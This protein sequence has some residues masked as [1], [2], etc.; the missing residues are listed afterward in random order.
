MIIDTHSQLRTAEA[1]QGINS[2]IL[3]KNIDIFHRQQEYSLEQTITDMDAAGVDKSVIVAVDAKP[4]MHIPNH[5]IYDAT[6]RF[7]DRFIGF[8]SVDPREGKAAESQLVEAAEKMNM[9]G[10]K[11]IPHLLQMYPNDRRFYALYEI[12]QEKGLPVLFHSGTAFHKHIKIKYSHPIY[13]DDVACDFPFLKIIIAHFGFPWYPESLALVHRH[14][15][16]Y[17]NIAGWRPRYLPEMVIRYMNGLLSE[18]VLFGSDFPLISRVQILGD[19]KSLELKEST[20][21]KL[22]S[23]NPKLLL[24][25]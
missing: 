23:E 15:F 9:K 18:K 7:P 24:G 11:L 19:L 13:L 10:L 22:L 17:F 12:A 4:Y 21:D 1:F 5:L 20:L 6:Q 14:D 8:A 16:V 3:G 25:L 2:E